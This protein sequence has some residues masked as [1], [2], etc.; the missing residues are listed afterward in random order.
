MKIAIFH[1]TLPEQGR[2]IGGVEMTVHLLANSLVRDQDQ[3]V[4]V[5]SS[6]PKPEDAVYNHVLLFNGWLRRRLLRLFLAPI[7]LNFVNFSQFDVLHLHGDD[8][9]FIK[10]GLPTVRSMHGSALNEARNAP[11]LKRKLLLYVIYPL[12]HISVFLATK[13]V[14]AGQETAQ[15]YGLTELGGYGVDLSRF[16]PQQKSVT[17]LL[18]FI[19]T[20]EGRKRGALAFKTFTNE[21]LPTY[22]DAK[23]YMAIDMAPEHPSVINGGFPSSDELAAWLSKAW[24][25]MYPSS[26]EGFGIP[27]VEAMASGTAIVTTS[28][29]GAEQVLENGLYGRI[30]SDENF[31]AAVAAMLADESERKS[32]AHLGVAQARRYS[33][34]E[35]SGSYV[36]IYRSTVPQYGTP[37]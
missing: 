26:Y 18:C 8:W 5:F 2:K 4:T 33:W 20:W 12:E 17:P 6:S 1:A 13:S 21:V 19:G 32:R 10:R 36:R 28:N 25:F 27:Y 9:F 16:R 34:E 23:L 15:I 31:G 22:P 14:A 29:G 24:V 35:V 37:R 3:E 7:A 30:T 11:S